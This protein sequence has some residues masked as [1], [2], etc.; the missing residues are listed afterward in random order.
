L[1]SEDDAE[2]KEQKAESREQR[3]EGRIFSPFT[4]HLSP[5]TFY[6]SSFIAL[7]IH[8]TAI[9]HPDA[10]LAK[11]VIVQPFVVIEADVVVGAGTELKAGTVLHSGTRVGQHCTLGPYAVVGGLPMDSGFKGEPSLAVLEDR[12]DLRDF[13]TVHRA[14]G[15]GAETRV[16]RETL[17]MSYAHV[18][19]NVQVGKNCVLTTSVQLAGHCQIGDYAV[20][21]SSAMLHQFCRI[22]KYAMYAAGSAANQDI[23]PFSMAQGLPAK[24]F[25]LNKV[26]LQ[27]RG[28]TG[29]RYALIEKAI[30]AFRRKEWELLDELARQSED[31]REMLEFK[32]T[33]KR[34]ICG[35][36]G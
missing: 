16:G 8:P 28:I 36:V 35:F 19:H 2:S 25:R 6:L 31:V 5:F 34:G 30:R 33:S 15:E 9:I 23:L 7:M 12:V 24:H 18:S 4:F 21:G 1:Q 26:G 3:A 27:R 10:N 22:G 11:N 13:A 14:T 17:V 20:L 32:H 29:E